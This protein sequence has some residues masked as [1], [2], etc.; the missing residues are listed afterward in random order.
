MEPR[1]TRKTQ[2]NGFME[3]L[4][5]WVEVEWKPLGKVCDFKNGFAFKSSLFRD[6]GLPIIRITNVDGKNVDLTDVKCFVAKDYK[7]GNPLNY[8]IVKGDILIAMSGAT[9]GKIGFYSSEETAYLN[10]RVGKFE[11]QKEILNNRYLFH[12]LLTKADF[13]YVLASGGAQPNLSS[14]KLKEKLLIPIPCPENPKKSLEIQ[15]ESS[16]PREPPPQAL[17]EPDVNVSAH[18]AP[19]DQPMHRV[20]SNGQTNLAVF[21]QFEPATDLPF[22]DAL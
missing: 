14:N 17:T 8:P 6:S 10:Q 5:D 13:L 3:K 9:T 12:F 20:V 4:L 19:I 18:P 21:V 11:P 16:S 22:V 1:K 15:A 7:S 2:K